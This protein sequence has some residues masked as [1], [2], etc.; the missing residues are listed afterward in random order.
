MTEA[1]PSAEVPRPQ[2]TPIVVG[3]GASAGGLEALEAF[4][5]AAQP[6]RHCAFVVVQHLSADQPSL[7]PELIQRSTHLVVRAAEDD[8]AV[9]PGHVDVAPPGF[10]VQLRGGRIVLLPKP[11][12]HGLRL[13]I[14]SFFRSLAEDR[15]G[16]AVGVILSGMGSDGTLG[17]R[18]LKACAG[19]TFV[20]SPDTAGFDSMPRSAVQAG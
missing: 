11:E 5:L 1:S 10:E 19:A 7:L 14:D 15:P 13:P 12:G 2:Q 4:F 20:Q 17:L 8:T 3:I 18:A 16:G 9:E 6:L